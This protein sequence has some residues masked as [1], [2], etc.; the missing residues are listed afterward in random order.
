MDIQLTEE[1]QAKKALEDAN[2]ARIEEI[3]K[4]FQLLSTEAQLQFLADQRVFV[5]Y[6]PSW[7]NPR[8]RQAAMRA[9]SAH[10]RKGG[11]QE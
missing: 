8:K 9:L 6:E 5:A 1:E 11:K 10:L 7:S 2:E 3:R 4:T